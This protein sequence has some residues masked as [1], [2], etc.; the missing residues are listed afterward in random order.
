MARGLKLS[1]SLAVLIASV[2]CVILS[3][4]GETNPYTLALGAG[5]LA[6]A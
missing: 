2:L 3:R 6:N 4:L 1:R 5:V